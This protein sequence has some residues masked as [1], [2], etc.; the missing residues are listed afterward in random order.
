[1]DPG[2]HR[3]RARRTAV[4]TCRR[5]I[6]PPDGCRPRTGGR[7]ARVVLCLT[8]GGRVGM[9]VY[10]QRG[11]RI[12]ARLATPHEV[13]AP[14]TVGRG[15]AECA[16]PGCAGPLRPRGRPEAE[17]HGHARG[18]EWT[19]RRGPTG[20][21]PQAPVEAP[22]AGPGDLPAQDRGWLADHGIEWTPD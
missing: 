19:R 7:P 16:R 4:N 14:R 5:Y 2:G 17:K 1:D 20:G 10:P 18:H 13:T 8:R 22:P 9:G 12:G 3:Y 15:V 11:L 21:P 6:G